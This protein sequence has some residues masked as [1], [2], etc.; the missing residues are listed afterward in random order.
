MKCWGRDEIACWERQEK[1]DRICRA[2]AKVGWW[3]VLLFAGYVA[4]GVGQ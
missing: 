1:T 3:A 2:V 4:R